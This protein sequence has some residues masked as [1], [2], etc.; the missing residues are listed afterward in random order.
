MSAG[1]DHPRAYEVLNRKETV[2]LPE[3]VIK[4]VSAIEKGN[5]RNRMTP[6]PVQ[7][8]RKVSDGSLARGGYWDPRV[9]EV[10]PPNNEKLK[11]NEKFNPR[12]D[13]KVYI[14][15]PRF[16][17]EDPHIVKSNKQI[18]KAHEGNL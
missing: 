12:G 7:V 15:Y 17:E 8:E 3:L 9:N 6:V 16:N 11:N 13:V 18:G 10:N 2:G 4:I 1:T 14:E 5:P